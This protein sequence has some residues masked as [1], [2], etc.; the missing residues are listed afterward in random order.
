MRVRDRRIRPG[1]GKGDSCK[2]G[3]SGIFEQ[4]INEMAGI[5]ESGVVHREK[6]SVI[7][8]QTE[9]DDVD[10]T[11]EIVAVSRRSNVHAFDVVNVP[12]I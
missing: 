11:E 2:L 10:E 4:T 12:D 5:L 6:E 8:S 1:T 3:K 7:L 9:T